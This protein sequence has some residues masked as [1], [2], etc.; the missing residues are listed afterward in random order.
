[1]ITSENIK[2][3]IRPI[4]LGGLL[5]LVTLV[6]AQQINFTSLD[7]GR[8]LANGREVWHSPG[9]L[10]QNFYSY[11]EPD[12]SFVNHHWLA[13]VIYYGIFLLGGFKLLS[14][15]NILLALAIFW[16]GFR[17][18]E[19]KAGFYWT[20]FLALPLVLMLSQ[21]TDIRPELFSYFFI[22]LTWFLLE[23]TSE[24]YLRKYLY[25]LLP[26]FLVWVNIHI[27][28]FIGLLLVAFYALA[29]FL[30]PA[31]QKLWSG[32]DAQDILQAGWEKGRDLIRIFLL[33]LFI[34]LINP[35]TWR[36]LLYPFNILREYGYEI[37][38]NKTIFFLETLSTNPA[39]FIFK[40]LLVVLFVSFGAYWLVK[41]KLPLFELLMAVFFSGL[42]LFA[43]RN[44][45]LFSLVAWIISSRN[46]SVLNYL[47][48]SV[49]FLAQPEIIR[50]RRYAGAALLAGFIFILIFY[51][52]SDS[53]NQREFIKQPLGINVTNGSGDSAQFFRDSGLRGPIF[54]NYD[55]GSALTFWLF[56]DEKVFVDNRPEA[57]SVKFF[58]DIYKPMQE[59]R[60]AWDKISKDYGIKTVYF[61][62]TDSTPWARQFVNMIL[63]HP[64][65]TLVY[66]DRYTVILS[67]TKETDDE[68]INKYKISSVD[69][70][71]QIRQLAASSL[72]FGKM[73]LASL[74]EITGQPEIAVEI[75][76]QVLLNNP[77][78]LQSLT[79]LGFLY[80]ASA[81]REDLRKAIVYFDRALLAG[82]RL[83]GIYNQ[84]GLVYWNM[85]DYK[86]A[87]TD[88]QTAL[89]L[90]QANATTLH[91][92]SELKRLQTEKA[93][94]IFP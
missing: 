89:E 88:W 43:S 81:D 24:T 36:G 84:R 47:G 93:I 25:W 35:N 80:S 68:I 28:F 87:A 6:F 73:N 26:L 4:A 49:Q 18:A 19:K 46:F 40:V 41:R 16:L 85:G 91:Y 78:D 66:F 57:Y 62:H 70:R 34:S 76:R 69:F 7:L 27:Y 64:D 32:A 92:L 54:N 22:L 9:L 52:W 90:D 72:E 50:A 8:H 94:P 1:M 61:S 86:K 14:V 37:A 33:I 29:H 48:K 53:R 21:R 56:P 65:W 3:F 38:E 45:A 15:F 60:L 44:I 74:A 83:P 75:Y 42:G 10:F 59:S 58:R 82:E 20:A 17:L 79:S 77:D 55:L 5:L 67:L 12:F 11:T 30:P 51:L 23:K 2:K 63:S 71:N 13:G 39:F 31:W